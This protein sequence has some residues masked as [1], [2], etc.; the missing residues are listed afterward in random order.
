[1]SDM[2]ILI[3]KDDSEAASYLAKAF[4]EA[5]HVAD[6]ALDGVEGYDVARD[7]GYD[8]LIVDRM[9]PKLDGLSLIGGLRVQKI[10]TPALAMFFIYF[11]AHLHLLFTVTNVQV[12]GT[13][14]DDDVTPFGIRSLIFN[15]GLTLN[16]KSVKL[17]GTANHQDYH[18]ESDWPR[19]PT[20]SNW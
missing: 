18:H 17:A 2:R 8:V 10:D 9:L 4:R 7:E 1:M 14:V 5:G 19:Q 16:G 20:G 3:I 12:G 11:L 15:N 13:T 6:C